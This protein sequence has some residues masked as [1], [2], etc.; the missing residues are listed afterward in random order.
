MEE[1]EWRFNMEIREYTVSSFTRDL[2]SFIETNENFSNF[3]LSGEVSGITYHKSGHLY[4]NLKDS[5]SVIKCVAFSYKLKK[6][7][8]D[9]REGE[10][11]RIFGHLTIYEAGGN[12]QIMVDFLEKKNSKGKLYEE[13]EK[14]KKR[15]AEKGYFNIERK[16]KTPFIPKGIGI[17]TADTGAAVRDI[18]NTTKKRFNNTNIFIFPAKVQGEGAAEEIIKGIE[19]LNKLDEV[20]I[21]II[22]RGGGSIEDLWCFNNENLAIAVY[23]SQKPIVSA[24]GHEID[25]VITDFVADIRAATPTQAAEIVIPDKKSVVEK[26]NL[27]ERKAGF[28]I[29][30]ILERK[31]KEISNLEKTYGIRNVIDVINNN[32]ENLIEMEELLGK[33]I[34][35]YLVS[36]KESI[37]VKND[38]LIVLNPLGVLKRGYSV[39]L[40]SGKCLTSIQ[41]VKSGEIIKTILHDGEIESKI[42]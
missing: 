4:F 27:L 42:V 18:I 25:F 2:K 16:R 12:Y 9:L 28:A 22:G 37:A 6:I 19:V 15:L 38:K 31:R 36:L 26:L 29:S 17:V 3:Y 1:T 33:K 34:D 24:V 7:P 23:N 39:T 32:R 13:F 10:V 41:N 20:D 11:L 8:E 40:H 5:K 30:K 14:I 35:N 21:I